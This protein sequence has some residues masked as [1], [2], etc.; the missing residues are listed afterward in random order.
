M[1]KIQTSTEIPLE[2]VT[3]GDDLGRDLALACTTTA[4]SPFSL[5]LLR[6]L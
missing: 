4:F 1:I 2:S 3:F 6:L 5:S